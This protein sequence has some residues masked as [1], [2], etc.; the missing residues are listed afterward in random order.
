[1]NNLDKNWRSETKIVTKLNK[2][3]EQVGQKLWPSGKK[4]WSHRTKIVTKWE[5]IVT[6][7]EKHCDQVGQ[8]L[9]PIAPKIVT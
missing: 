1:M 4:L 8:K 2:N 5:K 9:W 3:Y 6:K 7:S